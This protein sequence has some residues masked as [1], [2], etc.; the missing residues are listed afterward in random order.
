[1]HEE[2]HRKLLWLIAIRM[3]VCASIA[4]SAF[5]YSPDTLFTEE[6][7]L[8]PL[9]TFM[10]LFST[11]GL[12]YVALLRLLRKVP[13][14][15]A[16]IQLL[17]DLLLVTTLIWKLQAPQFSA[18][19]VVVIGV[20]T[21]FL[22]RTEVL[23]VAGIA[24]L[25]YCPAALRWKGF[26]HPVPLADDL[27][28]LLQLSY[29]LI[30]HLVG[31]YGIAILTSYL[32]SA[33]QRLQAT[34]LDL[35]Y[36]RGLHGDVIRS[37]SSGVIT[38]DLAG[39]VASINHSGAE[40]LGRPEVEIV[41]A[42]ITGS[43]MFSADEWR[44]YTSGGQRVRAEIHC[45][46]ADGELITLGVTLSELRDGESNQHGYT[47]V[48]R[49]LTEWRRLEEKV[50]IQDRMAAVGQMAAGL[51]HEVGNPLAAI[52]GSVEMLAGSFEGG[53]SQRQLLDILLK[54]SRRL[55]RTVKTFLLFA[56]PG[57]RR[58]ADFDIAAELREFIRLLRN[59]D[60]V[61]PHHRIEEDVDPPSAIL[62][63]D[64]DQ[65]SQILWNLAR[66][67]LQAM[68]SAGVLKIAGRLT[69]TGYRITFQ[70]TGKGMSEDERAKLF[71]P[72][73]SFFGSGTGLGMAIVYRIV[74]EHRGDIRVDSELGKGTTIAVDLPLRA[75]PDASRAEEVGRESTPVD[76]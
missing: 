21:V 18:L 46:R 63:A 76:R 55:D 20:A 14:A 34:H 56:K 31:F 19:Y 66:N 26:L 73:K 3:L 23:V 8:S 4:V 47:L 74:E 42:H 10:A 59:S 25:I 49:D 72:F 29:N 71:Q 65:V 51:A 69:D 27:T 37:M 70:D 54:E 64:L 6:T 75:V 33:Q 68:P 7:R 61:K 12:F 60:D 58:P 52:S 40:I 13:R 11:Q 22:H 24:W 48:F 16:W 17:G 9:G 38:T 45:S 44:D 50:R 35:S 15:Q 57:A 62:H 39:N 2:L 28:E 32:K 30:V 41:G 53:S 43:G 1:M 5:L 36:L 67:A